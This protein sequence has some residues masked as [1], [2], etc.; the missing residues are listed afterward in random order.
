MGISEFSFRI[1]H[2]DLG[3]HLRGFGTRL[4]GFG[5]WGS[6][7]VTARM[8]AFFTRVSGV[9]APSLLVTRTPKP[10]GRC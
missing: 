1:R 9:G 2:E 4:S 6:P 5:V 7:A 10:D 8:Q 3:V